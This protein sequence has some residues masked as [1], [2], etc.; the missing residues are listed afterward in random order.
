MPDSTLLLTLKLDDQASKG[1]NALA[2]H[3]VGFRKDG[4]I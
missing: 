2:S 4:E 1:I 3:R